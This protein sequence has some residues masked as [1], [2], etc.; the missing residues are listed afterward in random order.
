MLLWT[1]IWSLED[2]CTG[3]S[4]FEN[5]IQQYLVLSKYIWNL[6]DIYTYIYL[7]IYIYISKFQHKKAVSDTLEVYL[8]SDTF[9]TDS[10]L[11]SSTS[12]NRDRNYEHIFGV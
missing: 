5:L 4:T 3:R 6:V 7:Y 12:A 10:Y 1:Y 9:Y 8:E 2:S 11:K